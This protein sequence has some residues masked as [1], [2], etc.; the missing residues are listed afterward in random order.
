ASLVAIRFNPHFGI[1]FALHILAMQGVKFLNLPQEQVLFFAIH[2]A[3]AVFAAF[4]F[5]KVAGG[6][7]AMIGVVYVLFLTGYI[8]QIPKLAISEG[9]FILGLIVGSINGHSGTLLGLGNGLIPDRFA[10]HIAGVTSR[11]KQP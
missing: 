4:F 5:D 3:S 10:N 6:F 8:G 1:A 2:T 9:L 7:L 11:S